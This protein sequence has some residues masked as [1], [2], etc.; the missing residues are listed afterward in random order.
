MFDVRALASFVCVK[1]CFEFKGLG[2]LPLK[3][4]C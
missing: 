3:D 2:M 4:V 1:H